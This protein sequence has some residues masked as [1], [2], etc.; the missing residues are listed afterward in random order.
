MRY[1][2]LIGRANSAGWT[3]LRFRNA[4]DQRMGQTVGAA[5]ALEGNQGTVQR[6]G[7]PAER[8]S[9]DAS[10]WRGLDKAAPLARLSY[11]AGH[12]LWSYRPQQVALGLFLCHRLSPAGGIVARGCSLTG[13]CP[14]SPICVCC[15]GSAWPWMGLQGAGMPLV[16]CEP[17]ETSFCRD[18]EKL[19]VT[20]HCNL[21]SSKRG[22]VL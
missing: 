16:C 19:G 10:A 18:S 12:G 11:R 2:Y 14:T 8:P 4:V 17:A 9:N 13:N 6:A 3:A 20:L 15:C 7:S 1:I 5:A 22:L 21:P